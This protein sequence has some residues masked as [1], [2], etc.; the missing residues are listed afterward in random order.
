ME[1]IVWIVQQKSRIAEES[2]SWIVIRIAEEFVTDSSGDS[3]GELATDLVA[4]VTS[5][6]ARSPTGHIS[7]GYISLG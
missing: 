5:H 6:T 3:S 7:L 1:S 4:A 2:A